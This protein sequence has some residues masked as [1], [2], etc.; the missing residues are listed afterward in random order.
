MVTAAAAKPYRSAAERRGKGTFLSGLSR[1]VASMN[2]FN[3]LPLGPKSND[4][5]VE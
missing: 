2:P 3:L 1:L 4:Y 5:C